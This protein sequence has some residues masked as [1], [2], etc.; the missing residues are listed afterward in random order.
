MRLFFLNFSAFLYQLDF[1]LVAVEGSRKIRRA[2]L[3]TS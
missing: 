3:P 2:S 1:K